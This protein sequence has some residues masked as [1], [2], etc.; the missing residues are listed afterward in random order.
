MWHTRRVW[1]SVLTAVLAMPAAR[2]AAAEIQDVTFTARGDGTEQRYVLIIPDGFD[3]AAPVSLLFALHGHGA[4]RW[5]FV[6]DQ[7]DECR[8]ARE[9]AAARR[10]VFVSPDYR[11]KTSWMGPAAEADMLQIID[12]LRRRFKVEKVVLCGGSMGGTAALTFATL[13]PDRIDGVV[14]MNGTAN[15]V[16]FD[17]FQEAI[18]ASYGGSKTE[19]AAEYRKRSAELN[20]DTLT[21]PIAITVGGQ[22]TVVPPESVLRL[23]SVLQ[24]QNRRVRLIYRPEGSHATNLADATAAFEF[25]L[26][27]VLATGH[28]PRP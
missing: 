11:A 10:M 16:E 2:A 13:H 1:F 14:S 25:V 18:A 9:A 27:Q 28:N 5:Q 20:A 8:A 26:E 15:L 24:K 17:R 4:D 12:D 22:D 19:K 7:R 21:M 23:A 6:K 3:T